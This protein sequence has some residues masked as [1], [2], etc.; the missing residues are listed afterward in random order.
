MAGPAFVV[1]I[2]IAG[3]P[4]QQPPGNLENT[5]ITDPRQ[6]MAWLGPHSEDSEAS[7]RE[8]EGGGM[9]LGFCLH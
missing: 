6:H 5:K 2:M 8:R 1:L 3:V 9:G 4:Q 7:G